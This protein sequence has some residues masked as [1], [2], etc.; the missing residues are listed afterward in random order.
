ME[1]RK[2]VERAFAVIEA[3]AL[4]LWIGALAGFAFVFAPLAFTA[5]GGDVDRFGA[6]V[7]VVLGR[8][9]LMGYACGALALLAVFVRNR[10]DS[11]LGR[12]SAV[13]AL[14][15][16]LMLLLVVVEAQFVIPAV[17]DAAQAHSGSYERLHALSSTL[18]GIVIILGFAALAMSVLARPE[19]IRRRSSR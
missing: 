15:L 9:N 2:R 16:V 4:A 19:A 10:E 3:A 14:V 5:I 7:G 1:N 8:L 18:Y 13:R 17:H 6:L 11:S 12:G